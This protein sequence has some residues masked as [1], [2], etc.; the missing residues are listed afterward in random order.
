MERLAV[1]L[2]LLEK[3]CEWTLTHIY[4]YLTFYSNY[5][6]AQNGLVITKTLVFPT[7]DLNLLQQLQAGELSYLGGEALKKKLNLCI[8]QMR[9]QNPDKPCNDRNSVT[10]LVSFNDLAA[11]FRLG[12]CLVILSALQRRPHGNLRQ[13]TDLL[14]FYRKCRSN[15][16]KR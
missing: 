16:G 14:V 12:T 11:W 15:F 13:V 3:A 4:R 2:Y 9:C 1:L 8:C 7:T 6:S 10:G 5:T